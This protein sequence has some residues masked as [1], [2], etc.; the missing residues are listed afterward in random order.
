MDEARPSSRSTG[1]SGPSPRLAGKH[2]VHIECTCLSLCLRVNAIACWLQLAHRRRSCWITG[3]PEHMRSMSRQQH[4]CLKV[5][6]AISSSRP[7]EAQTERE[8]VNCRRRAQAQGCVGSRPRSAAAARW[9]APLQ[10]TPPRPSTLASCPPAGKHLFSASKHFRHS[11]TERSTILSCDCDMRGCF[12]LC[13]AVTPGYSH[14]QTTLEVGEP[15]VGRQD[16]KVP[17]ELVRR[18]S[19]SYAG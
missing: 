15:L 1:P 12:L 13:I 8:C 19:M 5:L 14:T 2:P 3:L 17:C 11:M 9:Q 10:A 18:C 16:E 7:L 4:H 6:P